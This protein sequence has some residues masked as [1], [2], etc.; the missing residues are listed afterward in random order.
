MNRAMLNLFESIRVVPSIWVSDTKN[1]IIY[2]S[3]RTFN[4]I[5]FWNSYYEHGNGD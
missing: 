3:Y 1:P 5:V 4:E 2:V